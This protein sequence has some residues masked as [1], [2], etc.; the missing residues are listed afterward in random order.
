MSM[1]W[2]ARLV[3]V[4]TARG[5]HRRTVLDEVLLHP[6]TDGVGL[7]FGMVTLPSRQQR[8][9]AA[10]ARHA[11]IGNRDGRPAVQFA[12]PRCRQTVT[13]TEAKLRERLDS[14]AARRDDGAGADD[15]V[16]VSRLR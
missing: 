3:V 13:W 1:T 2:D 5:A 7:V 4:C 15:E 10:P 12:C 14:L 8:A 16:D 11:G 6:R 9:N